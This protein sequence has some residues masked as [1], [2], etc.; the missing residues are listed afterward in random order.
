METNAPGKPESTVDLNTVQ[1]QQLNTNF[2]TL[3]L[4]TL[5]CF[6]KVSYR[7]ANDTFYYHCEANGVIF[8]NEVNFH[9]SYYL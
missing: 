2:F 7:P 3:A 8:N 1:L 4:Q 6:C 9:V 5:Q